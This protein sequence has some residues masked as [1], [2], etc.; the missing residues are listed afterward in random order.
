MSRS[1]FSSLSKKGNQ[2]PQEGRI[3]MPTMSYERS[4][5]LSCYSASDDVAPCCSFVKRCCSNKWFLEADS[6]WGWHRGKVLEIYLNCNAKYDV[7][8]ESDSWSGSTQGI[9]SKNSSCHLLVFQGCLEYW[10]TRSCFPYICLWLVWGE[11][12]FTAYTLTKVAL[13]LNNIIFLFSFLNLSRF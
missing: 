8:P 12:W 10:T 5:S 3:P 13:Y 9:T 4:V 1:S 11:R 7:G 6:R 2:R